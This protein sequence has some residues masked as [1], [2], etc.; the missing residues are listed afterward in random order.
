V[1]QH[2]AF[3]SGQFDTKFVERYFKPEYLS[4]NALSQDELEVAA[5]VA[6]TVFEQNSDQ[7]RQVVEA[8]HAPSKW[9]ANR[10]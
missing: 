4:G 1:M 10:R 2:E 6:A 3:Q 7:N 8:A 5:L 9:K